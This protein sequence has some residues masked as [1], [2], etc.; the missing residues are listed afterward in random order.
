MKR[1]SKILYFSITALFFIPSITAAH[2]IGGTGF[3]SV[4]MHYVRGLDHFFAIITVGIIGV[5]GALTAYYGLKKHG[6]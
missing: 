1:F 6:D 3:F 2:P 4:V 5:V